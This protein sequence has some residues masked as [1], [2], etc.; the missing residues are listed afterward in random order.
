MLRVTQ[1][2]IF[3]GANQPSLLA[4]GDAGRRPPLPVMGTLAYLHEDQG[5]TIEGDDVNFSHPATI[6]ARQGVQSVAGEQRNRTV[7][8]LL[9]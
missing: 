8:T 5:I 1:Q 2:K 3:C 7:L 9:T 4:A 6:V